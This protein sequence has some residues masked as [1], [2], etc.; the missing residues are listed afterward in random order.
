MQALNLGV[1]DKVPVNTASFENGE[2]NSTALQ[3]YPGK[4]VSSGAQSRRGLLRKSSRGRSGA[5]FLASAAAL[6]VLIFLC[7]RSQ[8]KWNQLPAYGRQLSGNDNSRLDVKRSWCNDLPE[9]ADISSADNKAEVATTH[10]PRT[11]RARVEAESNG[12]SDLSSVDTGVQQAARTSSKGAIE[13]TVATAQRQPLRLPSGSKSEAGQLST[14]E[15]Q[16]AAALQELW[17]S[18]RFTVDAGEQ[19]RRQVEEKAQPSTSAAAQ[20]EGSAKKVSLLHI[21]VSR[22]PAVDLDALIGA[23]IDIRFHPFC[24]LPFVDPSRIARKFLPESALTPAFTVDRPMPLLLRAYE[25]F[26]RAFLPTNDL[27]V[28]TFIAERLAAHAIHFQTSPLTGRPAY[29]AIQTLGLRFL[30]FD[31][32]VSVLELLGQRAEGLWWEKLSSSVPHEYTPPVTTVHLSKKSKTFN[33]FLQK[34][35]AALN[36]FKS[37]KRPS[38]TVLI[39]LKQFLICSPHAPALFKSKEFDPWRHANGSFTVARKGATIG[40]H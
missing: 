21:I 37:G 4:T 9:N 33:I 19:P 13:P 5:A 12:S 2:S 29:R 31:V 23:Y 38:C 15:L 25:L 28:V 18:K 26:S 10:K 24:H 34:L 22:K 32:I 17:G 14:Y 6:V 35:S 7:T 11:K 16:A 1:G 8:K 3:Q 27:E 39:T 36:T 40:Y 30:I 20:G